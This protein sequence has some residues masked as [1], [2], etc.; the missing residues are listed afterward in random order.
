M[1]KIRRGLILGAGYAGIIGAAPFIPA[2]AST[3]RIKPPGFDYIPGD[4]LDC[5]RPGFALHNIDLLRVFMARHRA[6]LPQREIFIDP[7]SGRDDNPGT[8][9]KPLKSLKNAEPERGGTLWLRAGTYTEHFKL[10]FGGGAK[11]LLVR[12]VDGPGTVVWR[13][14][15]TQP[16]EMSWR[17]SGDGYS[18]T[19]TGLQRAMHIIYR[20]GDEEVQLRWCKTID[21]LSQAQSGWTQDHATKRLSLRHAG[22]DFTQP[23]EID[24]LEIMYE[25]DVDNYVSRAVLFLENITFRGN[26]QVQFI[27]SEVYGRGCRFEYLGYHNVHVAGSTAFWQ[28][29]SSEYSLG[30]DGFNYY[31]GKE[32]KAPSYALEIDCV[33]RRN[34]VPEYRDFDGSRNKQGSSGHQRSV[35]CRINGVYGGNY[36]Q[37]IA[38]TGVESR[39]WMVG[40]LLGDPYSAPADVEPTSHCGLW[41]ENSAWLDTVSAGGPESAYGLWLERGYTSMNDCVFQGKLANVGGGGK[42]SYFDP[43]FTRLA[44]EQ[45]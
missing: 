18:S 31:D 19:P 38:D 34:G 14:P 35:I 17:K 33:G 41:L 6:V 45:R 36:G 7:V 42:L 27:D 16:S 11:P 9:D 29:C 4:I 15:G 28:R 2:R 44:G 20:A 13:S 32:T 5:D 8:R 39:T 23:S 26:T 25:R 30:G 21:Q 10:S 22:R 43:T 40:S 1:N 12:A 37:S 3:L 24:R